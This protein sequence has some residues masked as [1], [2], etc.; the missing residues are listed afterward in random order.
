VS[1]FRIITKSGQVRWI[2]DYG[3]PVWDERQARVVRIIGA[4]QDITERRRAE[5]ALRESEER[6][7]TLVETSSDWIWEVNEYNVYT[8]ASPKV[9]DLLGYE[10][11]EIVGRTPFDFMLP[12]EAERVR[13]Q[14]A[15]SSQARRAFAGLQ[16]ANRHK[17][18]RV[19]VLETS[20]VPIFDANGVFRGYRGIDRDITERKRAEEELRKREAYQALVLGSLP[21]AF[22]VAQPSGDYGGT[23]VSA[24]IDRISGFTAEQYTADIHLWASR[25][26]P[27]DRERVLG[28]FEDL[29][30]TDALKVEYRWQAADER[31]LWI[32]DQAVLTRDEN[33]DPKEIVGTW[34]DITERKRAE[35]ALRASE[36]RYRRLF[37]SAKDG[38]LILD[39]DT[40]QIADVNPFL[41]T[42]LGYSQEELLGKSLW[43]IGLFK[44]IAA[45]KTAFEELQRKGYVRYE[46]LPL[47]TRGGRR[48]AVEF[49]SNTYLVNHERVVQCNVRDITERRRAEEERER[50]LA[51]V[52]EQAQRV[53]QIMDTVPE[54]VLLLGSDC[55]VVLAN[56]LGKNGLATLANAQV[57]D[58]LT[59]LGDRPLAELLTSPPRGLWHEVTTDSR[60]FQ[61][62]ARPIEDGPTPKGWVLVI[63]DVTQQRDI[64]QRVQQQERLAAVGQL[65]AGIAHDFNNIMAV[66]TLYAGMLARAPDLPAKVYER[67]GTIHQQALRASD[68]IQQILDFSRRAV[69]ER[70]P[71]DLAVFIKEQVKLLERTLPESIKIELVYGRD[72]YVVNGDPTRLQQ[73][74]MNLAANARDAMPEGGRLRIDLERMQIEDAQRSPLPDMPTGEWVRVAVTDT[75]VGIPPDVLPH[76]F[77]PFFTTKT[78]GGG[79]GLGLAQVY[80][81]VGQHDGYVDVKTEVGVGTT[82]ALYLPAL[83]VR[84][85]PPPLGTEQLPQGHG[86]TILV[87][88]DA[89]ATRQAVVCGLETLGYRVLEAGNG[90]EALVAFEQ[91]SGEIELVLSDVVM[92]EMSGQALFQALRQRDPAV[93]VVLMTGHPL[94]GQIEGLRAQGLNGWLPKPPGIEKLAEVVA[95]ALEGTERR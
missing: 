9:Q 2:R 12:E 78:V 56:P 30:N 60:F 44:D 25:L 1:D 28:V 26:H 32:L 77:E 84:P 8:Y 19:V 42:L 47:E 29:P 63:R 35:E 6:F 7:R 73:A 66:I 24:Q 10:P 4:V 89:A 81:I 83:T 20:G 95:R 34:L 33:G 21:M 58:T 53:Q 80:G 76:I 69:L 17:D 94:E 37:E 54:G 57:G 75:G 43:E 40:G 16:N 82:F 22:Y 71:M 52:Q 48:I 39:A 41:T 65:A 79:T 85:Q 14:M 88:E 64:E 62:I 51:Q 70:G 87:V 74:V 46:D 91:H 92:P 3:R 90:Q 68:L 18:G 72:E 45:S 67:L 31:Y 5:E 38:I 23:W 27:E 50:L 49:V 55:R 11:A 36:I 15:E 86:E 61:T 13:A 93:S 59:R